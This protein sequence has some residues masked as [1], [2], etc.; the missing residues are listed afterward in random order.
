MKYT[1]LKTS[2]SRL[3][4]HLL[5]YVL[6]WICHSN[7][8]GQ[9]LYR[10]TD[11][12]GGTTTDVAT[13]VAGNGSNVVVG[14][15]FQGSFD[16]DPGETPS[17][18]ISVIANGSTGGFLKSID[19]PTGS[20]N[21]FIDMG[22]ESSFGVVDLENVVMDATGNVYCTG[23]FINMAKPDG[24]NAVTSASS[25]DIFVSKFD[26]SGNSL[27]THRPTITN[28][29]VARTVRSGSL[30]YDASGNVYIIAT[31]T[32]DSGI[33]TF[34]FGNSITVNVA[35]NNDIIVYK[36]NSAGVTQWAIN[37]GA[38]FQNAFGHS[39][40][41]SNDENTL[42]F[43]GTF[44]GT[45]DFDPG[46]PTA[47]QTATGTNDLVISTLS[48]T[49]GSYGGWTYASAGTGSSGINSKPASEKSAITIDSDNNL[50]V[51]GDFSGAVDF[52]GGTLTSALASTSSTSSAFVVSV[53]GDGTFRWAIQTEGGSVNFDFFGGTYPT[54]IALDLNNDLVVTGKFETPNT[55]VV[56]FD[57]GVGVNN[58]T[59]AGSSDGFIW[60]LNNSASPPTLEDIILLG[61]T[62]TDVA[63][64]VYFHT[65]EDLTYIA[66]GF[67]GTNS[68]MDGSAGTDN[69]SSAGSTDIFYQ[70]LGSSTLP[71]ELVSFNLENQ[72]DH[73]HLSWTTATELNNDFFDIQRTADLIQWETI[74]RVY[75]SGNSSSLIEYHFNDY[76][77]LPTTSYYRL[78]QVDYDGTTSY[79]SIA[80]IALKCFNDIHSYPNPAQDVLTVNS[81][82]DR[83]FIRIFNINGQTVN[84]RIKI[85]STSGSEIVF[86]IDSLAPGKYIVSDGNASESFIKK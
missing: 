74:G 39:I 14:G 73:V 70:R 53:Q 79:S 76:H 26:N 46:V 59:T 63:S 37:F 72:N 44:S 68:D 1:T 16:L 6:P 2:P 64:D 41:L 43:T 65:T 3:F 20:M 84:D 60:Y 25:G 11:G 62:G 83:R 47:N 22:T 35:G 58:Q 85:I 57:P 42:F 40:A 4:F 32:K 36:L 38:A 71:V 66:G 31:I 55:Y 5:I 45:I 86:D 54:G 30:I 78:K 28:P 24:T 23:H 61:G 80:R 7:L 51:I 67:S 8:N 56:D 10:Q 13:C 82:F 15:E 33:T 75:G 81:C 34:D 77:P 49:D 29:S 27:W 9:Y 48:T 21:W 69:L 52:G 12:Y 17:G 19:V 50:Y 18:S